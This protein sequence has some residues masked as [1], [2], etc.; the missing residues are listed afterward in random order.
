MYDYLFSSK[1][2]PTTFREGKFML[3]KF[4]KDRN[5]HALII[6]SQ[7]NTMP[8]ELA[9]LPLC[10]IKKKYFPFSKKRVYTPR[11]PTRGEF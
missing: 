6:K 4:K 8:F 7:E 2:T 10:G 11:L 5:R 1:I 9:D 3:I